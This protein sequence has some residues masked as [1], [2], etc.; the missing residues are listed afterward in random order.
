MTCNCQSH[1]A[2][3]M[4]IWVPRFIEALKNRRGLFQ[5]RRELAETLL[6]QGLVQHPDEEILEPITDECAEL[7]HR[8]VTVTHQDAETDEE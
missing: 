6:E 3:N 1:K 2:E 8:S 4:Y 7:T 5:V